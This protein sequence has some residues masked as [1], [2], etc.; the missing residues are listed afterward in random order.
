MGV[1]LLPFSVMIVGI[2][3][4]FYVI[5][6]MS[7]YFLLILAIVGFI[8]A[9][10]TH[11]TLFA[12]EYKNMNW[13]NTAAGIAPLLLTGIVIVFVVGY[14]LY[15]IGIRSNL[16][17]PSVQTII[18]SPQTATNPLTQIIGTG[19][20]S[21]GTASAASAATASAATA[22]AATASAA[23]VS[24]AAVPPP[25]PAPSYYNAKKAPKNNDDLDELLE[26]IFGKGI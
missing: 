12:S 2:F 7:L 8:F 19:L 16:S 13:L 22:S 17:L 23:A 20:L 5:P 4:A 24:A 6:K 10:Y 11:R 21:T 15:L 18:P 9:I 1:F 14:I 25:P 3:M 26:S